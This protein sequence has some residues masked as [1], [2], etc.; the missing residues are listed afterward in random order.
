M[1]MRV[2][3]NHR[4]VSVAVKEIRTGR[5]IVKFICSSHVRF[6]DDAV[7]LSSAPIMPSFR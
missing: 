4:A 3:L 2:E 1:T 5:V 6:D 7:S